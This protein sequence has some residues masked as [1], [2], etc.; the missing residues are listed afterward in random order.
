MFNPKLIG[1]LFLLF[2]SLICLSSFAQAAE[3][4]HAIDSGWG[5]FGYGIDISGDP[6]VNMGLSLATANDRV[7]TVRI[8]GVTKLEDNIAP[9]KTISDFSI[10]YG[11]R[12]HPE[13]YLSVTA[14]VGVA[15]TAQ[16]KRGK[17]LGIK[18]DDVEGKDVHTYEEI[19]KGTIGI[20]V[21]GEAY[22]TSL[23][24]VGIGLNA[25]GNIN[26]EQPF[27]ALGLCLHLG[28]LR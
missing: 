13:T 10:L 22:I 24:Y 8:A 27:L 1:V 21:E 19:R 4:S 23:R 17:Y 20:A 28:Y 25:F 16:V 11:K 3:Q 7:Y 14:N 6:A 15:F 18:H 26:A 9:D 12:F 2:G 5:T